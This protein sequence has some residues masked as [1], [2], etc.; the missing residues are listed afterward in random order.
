MLTVNLERGMPT[1]A[2]ALSQMNQ[3]LRTAKA[4]GNHVL[5][6]IH[7]YGSS[8]QGGAIRSAVLRELADR[9]A[10]GQIKLYIAGDRFSPFYEEARKA[11]DLCPELARDRDYTRTNQGITI[12]L[13]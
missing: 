10:R 3:A 12:V 11:I 9:Q 5:K 4:T 8:G 7:G 2:G 6:L 13:L 1:V